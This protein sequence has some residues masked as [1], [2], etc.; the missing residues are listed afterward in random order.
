MRKPS[1]WI[2]ALCLLCGIFITWYAW[3][4][5][6]FL[7]PDGM[8]YLDMAHRLLQQDFSPLLH[9]Y[10][11]P[12]YPCLLAIALKLFPTPA[13]EFQAA[14]LANWLIALLSLASFTFFLAQHRAFRAAGKGGESAASFRCRTGFAYMLFLWGTVEAIGLTAISPDL[15]VAALVYLAIG[16]CYRLAAGGPR[17]RLTAGWLGIT[18]GL[19]C[20]TKAAM[21]PLSAVLLVLLA[22]QWR[23]VPG[24]LRSL[25]ITVLAFAI[26]FGP[27][28]VALSRQQH[29]LT[30][31]EAGKLNYAWLVQ[32]GIPVHAGW[33]GQPNSSGTPV[34]PPRLIHSDPPVLEFKDTVGG[35]YPLWYDPSYFHQGIQVK[36]D[37]RKQISV[38]VK[39][40]TSLRWA[41]GSALYPLLAGLFVLAGSVS[42][43]QVWSGLSRSVL[44]SWS[45]V[46][47]AMFAM[48]TIEPRYIAAFMVLFWLAIYDAF[49]PGRLRAVARG[50]IG[51]T[52]VC[53][54]LFQVHA[55]SRTA[56]A[57]GTS[58]H[59]VV[60]N[61]LER[62]G[63]HAGDEIATVGSGF[64]A[65]YAHL[66][67]L[68]IVANI[69]WA[70]D[71]RTVDEHPQTLNDAKLDAIRDKL[72][73][74]HIKAIVSEEN[75]VV[76]ARHEWHSID[77]TGYTVL[78]LGGR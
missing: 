26:V 16:L 67:G 3:A 49:S 10:W 17:W 70:G 74:L 38:V 77:R 69:G 47:F 37:I 42:P 25:G 75:H 55:L 51:V 46:A 34:H 23:F 57:S 4:G 18:L 1:S 52:A 15:C 71:D 41:F 5:R 36:V 28:V 30:F 2:A 66:A 60:A 11:S 29:H 62:L 20:L 65:F 45:I 12:L 21:A 7:N 76:S 48:V 13:M 54:L 63:L 24:R 33:M 39:S 43:R 44:L 61:E 73:Q 6:G 72:V 40:L 8:S 27:F 19:A 68:R 50:A 56:A 64:E 53:I 14:H 9:P 35:T 22:V 31:G 78:M 59:L 32:G 58:P